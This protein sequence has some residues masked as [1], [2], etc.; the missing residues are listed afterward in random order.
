MKEDKAYLKYL[1]TEDIYVIEEQDTELQNQVAEERASYV[2]DKKNA[3][4]RSG[5]LIVL[6]DASEKQSSTLKKLLGAIKATDAEFSDKLDVSSNHLHYLVFSDNYGGAKYEIQSKDGYS[7]IA[8]DSIKT[9]DDDVPAKMKLWAAL[10][11][12]FKV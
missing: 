4:P 10:K 12:L 9:L 1:L 11:K 3:E 6:S 7:I 2:A 5:V 8:S